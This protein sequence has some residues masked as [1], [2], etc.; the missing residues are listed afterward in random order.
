M[1]FRLIKVSWVFLCLLTSCTVLGQ[2]CWRDTTCDGP[3]EAAFPG[4]WD[5]NIY[6]PS[7]RTVQPKSILSLANASEISSYPGPATL[8]GNASALVFDFGLEVGGIIHLSYSTSGSGT[9][10][11]GLA[12]SEAKNW[13]GLY[14]DSSN[15]LFQRGDGA[16]YDAPF[17][18]AG[19]HSYVVPDEKLRGGFRYLTVLLLTNS[20]SSG[21]SINVGEIELEIAFQPTWSNLR[22]YN[23]YFHCNDEELNR[24]WY[25]GAYTLQ[26][27]AV[28][29]NTGRA[30][31]ALSYGWANNGSLANGSTVI[32]DGAKRDRAVWPGDMGVAVPAVFVSTGDLESVK[33]A[34]EVMYDYQVRNADGAG[35]NTE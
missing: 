6:A 10:T 11:L 25:A 1:S 21:P 32:V 3:T 29:V 9:G 5:D 24:I 28:P 15:G 19:I 20:T 33:N 16:I 23:G 26:T 30:W 12:F 7:S 13:I 35:R 27:N 18:G 17:A 34:L 22:A 2:S 31:P 4:V 14:S 8:A